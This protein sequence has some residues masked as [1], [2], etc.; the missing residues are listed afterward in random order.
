MPR[1][2]SG[3]PADGRERAGHEGAEAR[4]G[5][6]GGTERA[7]GTQSAKTTRPEH[8]GVTARTGS[9]G[10]AASTEATD[11]PWSRNDALVTG[12]ACVLNLL[13]YVFF[14][15]PGTTHRVNAAGF[16]LVALGALPLLA[17]RRK[18]VLAFAAALLLDAV[19][20]VTVPLPHHF[21]AVLVVA[22][23][24]VARA[25]PGWTTAWAA[26]ATVVVTL[27][28]QSGG[29]VPEWQHLV[30]PPL[31]VA[32]VVGTAL[33]VNRWQR[34]V[35]ANRQ[36]LADRAVAEER[37]RI[38]RELHDIVAH[39]LTTMQLMAGGARANLARPEVA[40]EALVTLES[41]GRLALN[42]MRQL[43]DVLRADDEPE[44]TPALPQPGV[45]DLPALVDESRAAG[46]PTEF[47][48]EGPSR[49]LPPT[50]AL[51][52]FRVVQEALTNT[53]KHAGA[54]RATVR[55]TYGSESVVVEVRDDGT[56]ETARDG[57][58][59][60]GLV[61]MRERVALHGGSLSAGPHHEGGFHVYVE[62]PDVIND[63][64]TSQQELHE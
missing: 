31:T 47:A 61:G 28:S 40:R 18:P 15:D 41:S 25:R 55:L 42:E 35:A 62:L 59:G 51:T 48:T 2:R 39:H 38:A 14:D 34:E 22:L 26:F 17:R 6:A 32:L 5:E 46:L 1:K 9:T 52:L 33:A 10:S 20:A 3:D 50:V 45:A 36:L 7:E 64:T 21:G 60:Y 13:S 44:S 56:G 49:P 23:Y 54:S 4:D 37:R 30:S 27:A 58:P 53:R 16:L 11:Q 63:V 29:R 19:A 12:G 43:L 57:V 24:T 8:T